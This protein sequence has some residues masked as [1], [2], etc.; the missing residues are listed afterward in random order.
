MKVPAKAM[1]MLGNVGRALKAKSP[2]IAMGVGVVT[3]VLALVEAIK[4]T[5]KAIDI[6]EDHKE[7]VA[8]CKEAL[9]LN[10]ENYGMREYKQDIYGICGRT[11]LKLIKTYALPVG[12]EVASLLCFFGAH[13]IMTDR[14]KL[15]SA[16]L[17]TATDAYNS[18]RNKVIEAIGEEKEEQIR[19][20][21]H[22]EKMTTEVTDEKGKVKSV[23]K[24]IEAVNRN[25]LGPYDILWEE[26]DPGYD[27]DDMFRTARVRDV[28]KFWTERIYED[29]N[30]NNVPLA[31]IV[32][33]FKT[34]VEAYSNPLHIVAGYRQSDDDQAV[35]IKQRDVMISDP[36]NPAFYKDAT[37]LSFNVQ[38]SIVPEFVK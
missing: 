3:S 24:K 19:L 37:I 14:N 21:T 5:P 30:R 20:G 15:L 2:Q 1:A 13:K 11:G 23:T 25:G 4:Q 16:A 32:K 29:K 8:K 6:I 22:T 35:I 17:A 33:S 27:Q 31:E 7:E 10:D 18:Y 34:Q 36:E 12:M 9:E 38:G 28:A 26:G